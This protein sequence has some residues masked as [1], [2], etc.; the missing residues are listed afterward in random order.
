M[1]CQTH[2]FSNYEPNQPLYSLL[3]P[4]PACSSTPGE[5]RTHMDWITRSPDV[6]NCSSREDKEIEK[7]KI[8]E[9]EKDTEKTDRKREKNQ[10]HKKCVTDEGAR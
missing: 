8:R 5:R 3:A 1:P 7:W 4:Y 6:L 9:R 2:I 10:T